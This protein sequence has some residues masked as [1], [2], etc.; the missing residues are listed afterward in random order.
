M[1]I[2]DVIA[3]EVEH[4]GI[5]T[6]ELSRRCGVRYETLRLFLTGKGNLKGE[7][8]VSVSRELGLEMSDFA[9]AS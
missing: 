1:E 4:R 9:K 3:K 2:R 5:T 8:L 6:A 7:H